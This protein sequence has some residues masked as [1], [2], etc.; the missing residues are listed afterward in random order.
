MAE[1]ANKHRYF[2]HYLL[3]ALVAL[4]IFMSFT[5]LGYLHIEPVSITLSY[6]PVVIAACL[7]GPLES[8]LVGAVFGIASLFKASAS[9][10][11]PFDA[12]FSPFNSET[13]VKSLI[14]AVGC[15]ALFGFL[16]GCVFQYVKKLPHTRAWLAVAA[17]LAPKLHSLILY[18]TLDLLFPHT[19]HDFTSTFRFGLGDALTALLCIALAELSVAFYKSDTVTQIRTYIDNSSD[20]PYAS[21]RV[22]YL[23]VAFEII[24]L[25]F[26]ISSAIYFSDRFSF[27]IDRHG[28]AIT[29]SVANDMLI[30]QMQFLMAMLALTFISLILLI[31]IYKYMAFREYQG[32]IDSL[33]GIMGRRMFLYYC[34]KAQRTAAR[35]NKGWFIFVDADYFKSINDTLGHGA[36]DLVLKEIASNLQNILG[37]SGKAGR[38]GGDEFAAIIEKPISKE[39]L[40]QKLDEFL[41]N[42]AKTLPDRKVSCSIGAY[43]F[44]FPKALKFLLEETDSMLYKAKEMGRACYAVRCCGSES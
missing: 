26:A 39:E 5:F 13:P 7:L 9:Y 41:A 23:F 25:L 11:L 37:A 20:N 28:I 22:N 15:R 35:N 16:I 1:L 31:S 2:D 8:M 30:L 43:Q 40:E 27:M 14:L 33:T 12:I 36:G 34:E 24:T 10:V 4:E 44:M 19:G 21:K 18:T 17:G 38:L 6:I 32:E 42:I 3:G 29:P